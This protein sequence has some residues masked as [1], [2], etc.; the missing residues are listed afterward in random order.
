LRVDNGI[1]VD[2][3]L[4]TADV[5]IFAAGDCCSFPHPLFPG[6]NIRLEAWRNAHDQAVIAA[7][8]ILGGAEPYRSVPWF[9]SDQYELGLQIA[10][11]SHYAATE[12]VRHRPDGSEV[13]FGLDTEG[14]LVSAA[15]VASGTSIAR[16]IRVA[17]MLIAHQATPRVD[18]L[19]DA[20]VTLKSLL[21]SN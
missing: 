13:R 14:R 15:A 2:E 7:R 5:D 8:N 1:V 20:S 16:D 17:E 19:I 18:T 12:V 10:G 4:Q 21:K 6:A 3:F 9:W 11:L